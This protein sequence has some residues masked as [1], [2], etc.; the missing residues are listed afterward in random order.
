MMF[1]RFA[2]LLR[3]IRIFTLT[4]LAASATASF[5]VS[6]DETDAE[7]I[8]N[9]IVLA[10]LQGLPPPQ[11]VTIPWR[12]G[13]FTTFQA[14]TEEEEG[15]TERGGNLTG[16]FYPAPHSGRAPYAVLLAGCGGT[17]G[18]ANGLWLKLWARSLQDIGVGA[19]ALDSLEARGVK[20]GVCGE[21]SDVWALRRVDDAHAAL[22]WLASQPRVDSRRIVVMGMSNGGRTALLS[23]SAIENARFHRF[24]AAVALYPSCGRLPPHE[25][26]APSLL[27]LGEADSDSSLAKCEHFATRRRDSAFPPQVRIYPKASHLFDVYPRDEN[28]NAPEVLESRTHA[29]AFLRHVLKIGAPAPAQ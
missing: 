13:R 2:P 25:S 18:G 20:D 24:A 26:M 4:L 21:G 27:L 15:A 3:L 17:Y 10:W 28:Y 6:A 19:L 8:D 11:P 9:P 16:Q 23:V 7:E 29:L 14:G 5:A 22:A 12:P 1:R